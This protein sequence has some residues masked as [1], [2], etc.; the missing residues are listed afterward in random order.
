VADSRVSLE[1]GQDIRDVHRCWRVGRLD[2]HGPVRE[3]YVGCVLE[4]G[5]DTYEKRNECDEFGKT[6]VGNGIRSCC[7]F[8][9]Q[10]VSASPTVRIHCIRLL[11][12]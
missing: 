8:S 11:V 4:M 5:G 6:L 9:V 2:D 3:K 12:H 7:V 1:A 10:L